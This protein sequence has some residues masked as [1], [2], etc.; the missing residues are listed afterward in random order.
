MREGLRR[1]R[2][3]GR[4]GALPA[5][6]LAIAIRDDAAATVVEL[7]AAATRRRLD[8]QLRYVFLVMW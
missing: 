8:A 2:A 4:G 5:H 3:R 7:Q 1:T 6:A